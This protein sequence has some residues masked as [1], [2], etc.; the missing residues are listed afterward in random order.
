MGG[1]EAEREDE[2]TQK[3][4]Q[5]NVTYRGSGFGSPWPRAL[6]ILEERQLSKMLH[7]GNKIEKCGHN[8]TTDLARLRQTQTAP[9]INRIH[10]FTSKAL[11]RENKSR[12]TGFHLD[13]VFES[14]GKGCELKKLS[15]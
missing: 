13:S 11:K 7:S 3:V 15:F 6:C 5:K 14:R 4:D 8:L 10:S 9:L 12:K 1:G 2:A